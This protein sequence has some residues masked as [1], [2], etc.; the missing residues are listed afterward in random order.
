ME[1]NPDDPKLIPFYKKMV[2]LNL[3][4]LSHTGREGSFSRSAEEGPFRSPTHFS[5]WRTSTPV[6][7]SCYSWR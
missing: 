3:P 1:I 2:E 7:D 5:R 6:R 4:L